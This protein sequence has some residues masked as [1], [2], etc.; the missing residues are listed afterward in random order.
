MEERVALV[1]VD[2]QNDF[3]PG[4]ALA[5]P[6]GDSIVPIVNLYIDIFKEEDMPIY[7]TR[8]YHPEKTVHFK[9][10]GGI[11]PPHCIRETAGARLHPDLKLPQDAVIITKGTDPDE[12]SYSAFQ[13]RDRQGRPFKEVLTAAGVKNLYVGGLATDYC[14]KATV[15][16]GLREGFNAFLL[17]DAIKGVDLNEGD[18][19]RAVE[20]MKEKG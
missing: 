15:L 6:Y 8:D 13:G 10:Y 1:I 5:V 7:A 18:S 19:E 20:E 16:D 11:W 14:V 3:C 12:D 4:G 17:V 2:V 9:E